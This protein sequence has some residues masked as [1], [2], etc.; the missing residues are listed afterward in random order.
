VVGALQA[1]LLLVGTL[2]ET[3]VS[4]IVETSSILLAIEELQQLYGSNPSLVAAGCRCFE[5]NPC[6][7]DKDP[8]GS[9]AA[10]SLPF[11]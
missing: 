7:V 6:V 4:P 2:F 11:S 8:S 3:D 1:S 9:N 5:E 10:G